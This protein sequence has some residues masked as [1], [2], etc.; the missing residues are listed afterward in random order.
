MNDTAS[1]FDHPL[2]GLLLNR[3]HFETLPQTNGLISSN[4]C[5]GGG[6]WTQNQTKNSVLVAYNKK[7]L[8]SLVQAESMKYSSSQFTGW[9]L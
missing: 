2:F 3:I 7:A 6:I 8:I 4:R 1:W 5:N 9:F